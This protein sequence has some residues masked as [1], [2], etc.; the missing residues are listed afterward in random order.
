MAITKLTDISSFVNSIYERTVLVAREMNL[1][2]NLVENYGAQGWMARSFNTRPTVSYDTVSDGVDYSNPTTFNKSLIG[3][4]TPSE[5]IGQFILTDQNVE[6]DP[7]GARQQAYQELGESSAEKI[8]T[9]LLGVFPSFTTD[10]GDG[11]GSTAT[12]ANFS[13][14]IAVVRNAK[15]PMSGVSAVLHPYHWHDIWVEL[16]MPAAT[17]ANK[18]LLTTIALQDYFMTRMVGV[19]IFTSANI[20]VDDSDDAVS[21]IFHRRAIA[22]D[23]R[24]ALRI[25]PE[26]DASLRAWELNATMGYAVG[27]GERPAWGVKFTA[28][29]AEP[30]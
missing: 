24:R 4:L 21:G 20:S 2:T 30:S 17:Y 22:M 27:L 23:T 29:A 9:D 28:D 7:D 5:K 1:M 15:A 10:K 11:A 19:N 14:A 25:E 6:T 18:D 13:A 12:L 16:G 3:T 26:R 8:D